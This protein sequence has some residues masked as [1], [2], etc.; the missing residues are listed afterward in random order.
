M[1]REDANKAVERAR[2]DKDLARRFVI[3]LGLDHD[4]VVVVFV[5]EDARCTVGVPFLKQKR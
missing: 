2:L 5:L 1:A 4:N 3:A